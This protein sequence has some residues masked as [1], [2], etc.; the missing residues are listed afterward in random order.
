MT[1]DQSSA[2]AILAAVM[3]GAAI[4]SFAAVDLE[5][6]LMNQE[7]VR[8]IATYAIAVLVLAG[9]F[10]LI[11]Q[12]RGDTSQAWLAIGA[13]LGY[14]FRDAGGAAA[15]SQAVKVAQATSATNGTTGS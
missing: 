13:V 6:V 4:A 3:L 11:Y 2:I 12:G 8:T 10:L 5:G 15:T 14:T 9:A 1:G 7:L